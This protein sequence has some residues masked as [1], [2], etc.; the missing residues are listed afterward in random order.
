MLLF[1]FFF[2]WSLF[3]FVGESY[4]GQSTSIQETALQTGYGGPVVRR[5]N[6]PDHGHH[7]CASTA[8][9]VVRR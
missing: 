5:G 4:G 8:T 9:P 6:P 7:G 2:F 3:C 1:F